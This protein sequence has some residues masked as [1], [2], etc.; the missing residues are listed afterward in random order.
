M[1]H[2]K[3]NPEYGKKLI[4]LKVKKKFMDNLFASIE[5]N[6]SLEKV[7][8]EINEAPA[9]SVFLAGAF[10]F[11]KSKEGKAFWTKISKS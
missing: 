4:K 3:L 10:Y 11:D 5:S 8:N 9:F 7:I 2:P 1:T 6:E